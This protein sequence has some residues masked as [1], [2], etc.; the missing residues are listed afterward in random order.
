MTASPDGSTEVSPS[1]TPL[2]DRLSR[3]SWAST[4][5]GMMQFGEEDLEEA[6]RRWREEEQEAEADLESRSQRETGSAS[7]VSLVSRLPTSR[8]STS[9]KSILKKSF[10]TENAGTPQRNV[11]WSPSTLPAA[12]SPP[13][14]DATPEHPRLH[15]RLAVNEPDNSPLQHTYVA[16][17]T[18]LGSD[19]SR[20]VEEAL[21][22]RTS[23][24]PTLSANAS[25]D[26]STD[27]LILRDSTAKRHGGVM[28]H[29]R[30]VIP[31]PDASMAS[32]TQET[33][34][35]KEESNLLDISEPSRLQ[36]ATVTDEKSRLRTS[37][38]PRPLFLRHSVIL[39]EPLTSVASPPA[40][41]K[42]PQQDF[43]SFASTNASVVVGTD[44]TPVP[45]SVRSKTNLRRQSS[46]IKSGAAVD[47]HGRLDGPARA[48]AGAAVDLV[49]TPNV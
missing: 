40:S 35:S 13:V 6:E 16:D 37:T 24:S 48:M 33:R 31:S 43:H 42:S 22:S 44:G 2:Q 1:K 4:A 45:A 10:I 28:N 14:T 29:M 17:A 23:I 7:T 49:R 8:S 5:S 15:A 30:G 9:L 27:S 20:E 41:P 47:E 38:G 21:I 18:L 32:K 36:E 12:P 34:G 46:P 3:L 39:E 26:D 19:E 25:G 11:T